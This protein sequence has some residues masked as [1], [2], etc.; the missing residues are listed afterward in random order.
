[1]LFSGRALT[2][3]EGDY[4]PIEG[5][6]SGVT[7][8]QCVRTVPEIEWLD[9]DLYIFGLF[10]KKSFQKYDPYLTIELLEFKL[11]IFGKIKFLK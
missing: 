3:Q 4:S 11:Q 5:T 7:L 2:L 1:M 9:F 6:E 10:S 8:Q